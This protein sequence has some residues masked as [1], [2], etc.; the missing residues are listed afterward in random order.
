MSSQL[1][2]EEILQMATAVLGV[3]R[4]AVWPTST[5]PGSMAHQDV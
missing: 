4:C 2:P 5:L 1:K 3:S